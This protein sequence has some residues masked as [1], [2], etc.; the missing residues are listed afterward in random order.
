[1]EPKIMV[2][3]HQAH[4]I[5]NQKETR[6]ELSTHYSKLNVTNQETYQPTFSTNS[7]VHMGISRLQ[8]FQNISTVNMNDFYTEFPQKQDQDK[9]RIGNDS[10]VSQHIIENQM[11]NKNGLVNVSV[12]QNSSDLTN[13][14]QNT[15]AVDVQRRQE[16][17]NEK[18]CIS[19]VG[20]ALHHKILEKLQE[21]KHKTPSSVF[22]DQISE[23]RRGADDVSTKTFPEDKLDNLRHPDKNVYGLQTSLPLGVKFKEN[24]REV[25]SYHIKDIFSQCVGRAKPDDAQIDDYYPVRKKLKSDATYRDE[26]NILASEN[27]NSQGWTQKVFEKWGQGNS[28]QVCKITSVRLE[29]HQDHETTV[30]NPVPQRNHSKTIEKDNHV[31]QSKRGEKEDRRKRFRKWL[32][33]RASCWSRRNRNK[34]SSGSDPHSSG[35]G[36]S[37]RAGSVVE[38]TNPINNGGLNSPVTEIRSASREEGVLPEAEDDDGESIEDVSGRPSRL[39]P[40]NYSFCREKNTALELTS[41]NEVTFSDAGL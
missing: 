34:P 30:M 10:S 23:F 20:M 29:N 24:T 17:Q 33:E 7:A 41:R 2:N 18:Q 19:S 26:Q 1:M 4:S 16:T 25:P 21:A 27:R 3:M 14:L 36:D 31:D 32:T 13:T 5:S 37:Y 22:Q 8:V 12:C 11:S 9:H 40:R 6:K 35:A 39:R 28:N 15:E 38:N